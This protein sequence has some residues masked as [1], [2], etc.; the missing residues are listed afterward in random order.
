MT[1]PL[2]YDKES[3]IPNLNFNVAERKNRSPILRCSPQLIYLQ[4]P[5]DVAGHD[6]AEIFDLEL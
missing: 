2:R 5:L 3:I 6:Q 4:Q 1:G